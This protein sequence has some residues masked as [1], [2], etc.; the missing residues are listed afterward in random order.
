MDREIIES[1]LALAEK[2]IAIGAR[3]IFRQRE[4]IDELQRD[5]HDA[6]LARKTLALFEDIQNMHLAERERLRALLTE[7]PK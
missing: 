3:N 2:H 4:I 5:C 1:H 6:S 7:I